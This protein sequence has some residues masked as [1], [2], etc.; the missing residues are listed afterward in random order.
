MGFKATEKT[1]DKL[2]SDNIFEIPRNQR[3]Y[4]WNKNNWNELLSDL[5]LSTKN[6]S[7]HFIGS[8]VLKEE[9]SI[10]NIKIDIQ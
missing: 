6:S 7:F 4:V 8:L 1:I 2:F 10:N 9:Q 3:K 5:E